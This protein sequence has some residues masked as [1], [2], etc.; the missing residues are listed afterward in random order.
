MIK[1]GN[2]HGTAWLARHQAAGQQ[3][4]LWNSS[5]ALK[6]DGFV[7]IKAYTEMDC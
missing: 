1:S 2:R 4:E 5:L 3:A 6:T 7:Q